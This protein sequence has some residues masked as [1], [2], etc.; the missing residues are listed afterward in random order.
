[1]RKL[2][3]VAAYV[4]PFLAAYFIGKEI[5][6]Y[7]S[8]PFDPGDGWS[9]GTHII[10]WAGEAALAMMVLATATAWRRYQADPAYTPKL[11]A[12]LAS[13]VVFSLASCLA[14]WV[15]TYNHLRPQVAS[16]YAALIFRV[17][18]VPCVDIAA[19]LYLSI[20]SAKSL[21][22]YLGEMQQKAQAIRHLAE[23]EI[24]IEE[25]QQSALQRQEEAKQYLAGRAELQ[26]LIT[27][28]AR[29]NGQALVEQAKAA[30]GQHT[31]PLHL[32]AGGGHSAQNGAS[33]VSFP[34]P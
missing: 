30:V 13:F 14:Q 15:I 5:G 21:K 23:A 10:A 25:A 7:Y 18:M 27:E 11:M 1:V 12:A 26:N 4:F 29:I 6:D 20:M 28:I 17:G 34:G 9:G 24:A 8:G 16:D 19:L 31:T 3:T 22:H 2:F 33:V 32:L